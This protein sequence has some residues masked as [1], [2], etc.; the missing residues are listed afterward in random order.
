MC[1]REE[2]EKMRDHHVWAHQVLQTL[3]LANFIAPIQIELHTHTH[4]HVS[5]ISH[6]RLA[7]VGDCSC[8]VRNNVCG[9]FDRGVGRMAS[10]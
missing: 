8:N 4:T 9:N 7:S 5:H 3:F 10:A 1:V 6:P 2:R